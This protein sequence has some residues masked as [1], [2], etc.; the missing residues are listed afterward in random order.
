MSQIDDRTLS[1]IG[2]ELT[3]HEVHVPLYCRRRMVRHQEGGR[4][5][6]QEQ[7]LPLSH[8]YLV[9]I[10]LQIGDP[11]RFSEVSVQIR[12]KRAIKFTISLM[13]LMFM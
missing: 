9:S 10:I 8:E 11:M 4:I 2:V 5:T 3:G 1:I 13:P 12:S 7:S 6:Y